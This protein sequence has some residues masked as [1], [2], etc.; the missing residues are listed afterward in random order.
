MKRQLLTFTL[1]AL[2]LTALSQTDVTSTYIQNAD[3]E[4]RFAGWLTEGSTK[5]A[6]DGFNYQI[7]SSF[8]SKSGYVYMEKWV[9]SGSTVGDYTIR[10]TLRSLPAGTYQL[11]AAAMGASGAY[12]YAGSN[13][14]VVDDA[15]DYSVEFTC[16]T[17]EVEIGFKTESCTT[18]WVA[19]DNFR[20]Y[21]LDLDTESMQS[22]LQSLIS[23]AETALGSGSDA[24]L[25]TAISNAEALLTSTDLT[26]VESAALALQQAMLSYQGS[27]SGTAPTVVTN[28]YVAQGSTV[29]LARSTVTTNGATVSEEGFCWSI[30]EN[31]TILDNRTTDYFD[32]NGKVFRL[33]GLSAETQYYIRAYAM[34]DDNVVS[35][36]EPVRIATKPSGSVWRWYSNG[37]S[38]DENYRIESALQEC[39]WLYNN[40]T[41]IRNFGVSVSYNSGVATADCSYGGSMRVGAN[42]SYQQTGTILH[43]TNHGVG[44]GQHWTWTGNSLLRGNTSSGAWLGPEATRMIQFL[45]NDEGAYVTGDVTHMWGT[46]TSASSPGLKAWGI[47][48]ASED[49]YNPSDQLLYWGNVFITNSLHVDGLV[50]SGESWAM[51]SYIFSQDDDTKYY[52]KTEDSSLGNGTLLG[53]DDDGALGCISASLAQAQTN[54]NLAWYITYNPSTQYY[55][56]QNVGTGQYITL[57][58]SAFTAGSSATEVHLRLSFETTELGGEERYS[59]AL[60]AN[61]G[62]QALVAGSTC[63]TAAYASNADATQRWYF[64]TASELSD[65]CATG[66]SYD[67]QYLLDGCDAMLSVEHVAKT[68]SVDDVDAALTSAMSTAKNDIAV[69]T[70]DEEA[71]EVEATLRAAIYTFLESSS[72]ISDGAAFDITFLISNPSLSD[73]DD[74]WT[75]SGTYN[76]SS[77]EYFGTSAFDIFYTTEDVLPSGNYVLK[78]QGFQRPGSYGDVYT[79]YVTNSTDNTTAYLY[80]SESSIKLQNMWAE[81]QTSALGSCISYEDYYI[82]DNMEG[83]GDCFDAGLY[84][85]TLSFSTTSAG[86]ITFGVRSAAVSTNYWTIFRN[87]RL[88]YTG[89]ATTSEVTSEIFTEENGYSV[90]T[91]LNSDD[92]GKYYYVLLDADNNNERMLFLR[93]AVSTQNQEG[94]MAPTYED[95][96]DPILNEDGFWM[97]EY[98]DSYYHLRGKDHPSRLLQTEWNAAW[99]RRTND[100]PLPCDW[101]KITPAYSLTDAAWTIEN[102]TYADNFF[103]YWSESEIMYEV[104]SNKTETDNNVGHYTIYSIPRV[105]ALARIFN[106][107]AYVGQT[108][109][110]TDLLLNPS[111]DWNY[112]WSSTTTGS[113]YG[114][115]ASG[116]QVQTNDAFDR[117][118]GYTYY[119]SYTGSSGADCQLSQ[120][121]TLPAGNY[122]LTASAYAGDNATGVYLYAG[123]VQTAVTSSDTYS[124]DFS[125]TEDTD[126][127]LGFVSSGT[128]SGWVTVD[129]FQ[130]YHVDSDISALKEQLAALLTQPMNTELRT[131]LQAIS[132]GISS[133]SYANITALQ[134]AISQ[135][136]TSV[137]AYSN[138]LEMTGYLTE[139]YPERTSYS[140]SY[141]FGELQASYDEETATNDDI[142]NL[143]STDN[144]AE[145]RAYERQ[146][147]SDC[148]KATAYV[149]NTTFD[150]NIDGW[151]TS[152]YQSDWFNNQLLTTMDKNE[153]YT[154]G[155]LYENWSNGGLK[156][157]ISQTVSNLPSGR[158]ALTMVAFTRD[159]ST[160]NYGYIKGT[161]EES[162]GATL[163]AGTPH[164]VLTDPVEVTDGTVE[165]GLHVGSEC[166]WAA[167]GQVELLAVELYDHERTP[168]SESSVYG[169]ICLPFNAQVKSGANIYSAKLNDAKD[170]L[171]LIVA[172]SLKQG[173]AYIYEVAEG[174]SSQIFEALYSADLVATAVEAGG[175]KLQG[176][177]VDTTATEGNYV[178]QT[179]DN[180]QAFYLVGSGETVSVPAYR[181]Y[182]TASG[183]SNTRVAFGDIVTDGIEA[184]NALLNSDAAIY[185][186]SGRRLSRLQKGVNIV[187]GKKVVVK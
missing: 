61:Y 84:E 79:D 14:T 88:Y 54:D 108:V 66:K 137:T 127:E 161:T 149:E 176:T 60:T 58:N 17:G 162:H 153:D 57:S 96:A 109:E 152:T 55:T 90:V 107:S 95:V 70:T 53:I 106:T 65:C 177:L 74:G 155:N 62:S 10:Q 29:A 133:A 46:T 68:G 115:T 87:F 165:I 92:L 164:I 37:G 181:A 77:I 24:D 31:P 40:L 35:Y 51:P 120:T 141:P 41:S 171:T 117:K 187:N 18:N 43:E 156:G 47:N 126:V 80:A 76:Y 48:G 103:G 143:F 3:F 45:S 59:Y 11:T 4:S 159:N 81:A 6:V 64:L 178:L 136:K 168:K 101:T 50:C 170:E 73:S 28:P 124:V 121:L 23:E 111:I 19:V 148:I 147:V 158:Y 114:W 100:Q 167:L 93:D 25:Q 38:D 186:L 30:D 34:T 183:S 72:T 125:L 135:A 15:G 12:V 9:A 21:Q 157:D 119:E 116:G 33:E 86:T 104:A 112:T 8:S 132:D 180:E 105:T 175:G 110:I 91:E 67:I 97:L 1:C 144:K 131:E 140:G 123:D 184:V 49:S 5:G 52:I 7:N 169:T 150:E 146:I 94:H 138:L 69:A 128:N 63:S 145:Y 122:A 82:P 160:E 89:D 39:L 22:A 134:D 32:N 182:L 118:D 179:L 129:N 102:G 44:V 78:A 139:L 166:D 20:L 13:Q 154:T 36:G 172:D 42:S 27:G 113:T 83:A 173:E 56:F 99:Y 151:S 142:S 2:S 71:A 16:L 75:S 185:D 174:S 98:S 130:L 163:T 85:N 26:S